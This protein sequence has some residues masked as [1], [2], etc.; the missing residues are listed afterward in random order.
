MNL[1]LPTSVNYEAYRVDRAVNTYDER[2]MF[3]RNEDTGDWCVFVRMPRPQDP[4]P[5]MGFGNE[6]PNPDVV[7]ARVQEGHL[8]RHKERIWSEIV[9][10]QKQYRKDLDYLGDQAS[11]ESAEVV[12]H[13]L[14]QH[15]KS[16]VIKEFITSDV[17]KGGDA[18][19]A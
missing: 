3:A 13:F 14:R 17:P 7:L 6:V 11:E 9:E 2:L 16:P 12:E 1:W 15:G 18:S 8:V 10:S 5:L 19:D 4:F